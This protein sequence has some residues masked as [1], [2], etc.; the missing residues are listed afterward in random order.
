MNKLIIFLFCMGFIHPIS[1]NAQIIFTD[2][3]DTSINYP[4]IPYLGEGNAEYYLDMNNDSINDF[5]LGLGIWQEFI[6]PSYQP[7]SYVS[8]I[9]SIGNNTYIYANLDNINNCAAILDLNDTIDQ[10]SNWLSWIKFVYINIP[11]VFINCGV[12]YQ[13][14]YYGFRIDVNDNSHYG[15]LHLNAN[16]RGEF[17]LKSYA[18]NTAPNQLIKA[19][20]TESISSLIFKEDL[21]YV[22]ISFNSNILSIKQTENKELINNVIIYNING[23]KLYEGIINNYSAS[24]YLSDIRSGIYIVRVAFDNYIYSELLHF[25]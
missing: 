22:S 14:K 4:I 11:N 15:W 9:H 3:Q 18:Y 19:G 7:I 16:G 23:G 8:Q 21:K 17:V 12:P 13:D 6:S 1:S 25:N 5:Y 20:Q 24:I 10:N 2:I